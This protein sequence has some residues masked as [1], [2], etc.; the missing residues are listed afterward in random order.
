MKPLDFHIAYVSWGDGGKRR[1]VL[2]LSE[3]GNEAYVYQITTRY[4]S[5]S[6]VVRSKY[7][8][9]NDWRQSGLDKPSYIDTDRIISLPIT[10]ID[11]VPIGELSEKDAQRLFEFTLAED[12]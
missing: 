10:T 7:L 3:R 2:I 8:A 11:L 5:K 6:D 9:I 4:Q 1:P 12:F